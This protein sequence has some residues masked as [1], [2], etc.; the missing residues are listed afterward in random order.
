[1]KQLPAAPGQESLIARGHGGKH[2]HRDPRPHRGHRD[3]AL[4]GPRSVDV[5]DDAA[6]IP[7]APV[8]T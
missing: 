1:M 3:L 7:T 8:L 4:A 6:G 2:R 5:N